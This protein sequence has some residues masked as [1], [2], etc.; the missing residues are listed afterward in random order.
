MKQNDLL[1]IRHKT[2]RDC[3]ADF[4]DCEVTEV[5]DQD[6]TWIWGDHD[7]EHSMPMKEAVSKI[8]S[9]RVW[10]WLGDKDTM[11][12]WFA[13][14]VDPKRLTAVIAHELGHSERPWHRDTI[15]EEQKASR[16]ERVAG[17]AFEI[18]SDLLDHD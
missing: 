17:T 9:S 12:L 4:L 6:G 2:L 14:N 18:M 11:H 10:A 1:V 5:E 13:K 3:M 7:G 15:Q 16:Y 8:L